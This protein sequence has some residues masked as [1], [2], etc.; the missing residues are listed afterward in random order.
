MSLHTRAK[1]C[2][3]TSSSK[4]WGGWPISAV[5]QQRSLWILG[6]ELPDSCL[7]PKLQTNICSSKQC[8]SIFLYFMA[9]T[10]LT[11]LC[12]FLDAAVILVWGL[13]KQISFCQGLTDAF[14]LDTNHVTRDTCAVVQSKWFYVSRHVV[15]D[16]QTFP[17]HDITQGSKQLPSESKLKSHLDVHVIP[18][19]H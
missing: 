17:F 15:F 12:K 16:E 11:P 4:H 3:W 2:G 8:I 19:A 14:S 9:D 1:W 13:T 18:I 5:S 7:Y 6:L 10:L